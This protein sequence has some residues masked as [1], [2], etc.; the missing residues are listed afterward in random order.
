MCMSNKYYQ[1]KLLWICQIFSIYYKFVTHIH[2]SPHFTILCLATICNS[3]LIFLSGFHKQNFRII[4]FLFFWVWWLEIYAFLFEYN[5]TIKS[6]RFI[7]ICKFL[8]RRA[9]FTLFH[10]KGFAFLYF[11][12]KKKIVMSMIQVNYSLKHIQYG[13]VSYIWLI[14][15]IDDEKIQ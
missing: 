1:Y 8:T 10:I 5:V 3:V 2:N 15:T 7:S 13:Y 6:K 4:L 14:S 12:I 11:T 9:L